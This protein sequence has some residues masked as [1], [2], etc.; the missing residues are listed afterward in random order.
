MAS[1][2]T[3]NKGGMGALLK[4]QQPDMNVIHWLTHRLEL[5]LKDVMKK[6]PLYQKVV[7][8]LL[9]GL[10]YLYH[11]SALNMA[12]LRN[13]YQTLKQDG[14]KLL[15]PTWTDGT[16][17]GPQGTG[18]FCTFHYIIMSKDIIKRSI[19]FLLIYSHVLIKLVENNKILNSCNSYSNLIRLHGW[20]CR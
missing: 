9:K 8:I 15:I 17:F 2:N 10:F 6:I 20:C 1:I 3:G 12:M 19:W 7:G 4:N 13:T 5:S 14:K 16:R 18:Y 11:T